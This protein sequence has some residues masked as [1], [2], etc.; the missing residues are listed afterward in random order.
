[1]MTPGS[2]VGPGPELAGKVAIVTGAAHGQGRAIVDRFVAAGARVVAGDLEADGLSEL[3]EQHG[4]AVRTSVQ[5]VAD[6][7]GWAALT[8]LADTEL[9][10]LHI[11]VN[12]AGRYH[13]GP[14][15]TE[16]P[17]VFTAIWRTNTLGPFL[18]IRA[19]TPLI[20][21]S[22][23]GAIVNTA[24]VSGIRAY[25]GTAAYTAS[26]FALVGLA[27]VAALELA[28][29]GIRVNTVLP[30]PVATPMLMPDDPAGADAVRSRFA[31]LPLGRMGE[32]GEIAELVLFLAS[33]RAAFITGAEYVIDG[34]QS[35]GTPLR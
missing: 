29:D 12:N 30:G 34:G 35:V 3:R 31:G 5:D 1:M 13:R 8:A 2:D 20:R 10:G 19:C 15:E 17:E 25:A 23:G 9:G 26:K 11:L 6:P 18:G 32:A 22:G 28:R 27:Q 24:S 4:D 21:R 33:D 7:A 14:I 16:D